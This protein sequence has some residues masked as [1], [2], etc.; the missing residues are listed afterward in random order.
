MMQSLEQPYKGS[1]AQPLSVSEVSQQVKR[2]VE[3]AF[4]YVRV[5]GEIS[6]FKIVGSGH[7][8]FTLKDAGAVLNAVS[9]KGTLPRLGCKPEDGL[10]VIATGKLTIFPGKSQYQLVVERMEAAGVGALMAMLE[11]RKAALLA[12]GLFDSARK[13]P[14]PFLP[15]I[16]GVVT[17]P[18]GAVIRDILHRIEDRMPCRVLVIAVLVQG[19]GAA[20]QIAGAIAAFNALHA[21]SGLRP[22]T[23]IV[24]RGGGS[25]EDLWAFNEEIVVRAAAASAIPLISA[26]GHETD[27]TLIDFASDKRAP[28][29]TAAA[30]M[31]VPVRAELLANLE[32]L[33]ARMRVA[34]QKSLQH[35][36]EKVQAFAR[37]L[38]RP[39]QLL[40]I[41]TQRLDD[42]AERHNRSLVRMLERK[43]EQYRSGAAA[44]SPQIL[45]PLLQRGS[46]Q[47]LLAAER[48]ELRMTTQLR[49][50][51]EQVALLAR[52]LQS[53]DVKAVMQRGFA[54]IRAHDSGAL[55]ASAHAATQAMMQI[56]W[57]DGTLLVMPQE[58]DVAKEQTGKEIKPK[59]ARNSK[60]KP[61]PKPPQGNLF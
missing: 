29:P 61:Q 50:R 45:Q 55:I 21:D 9:W 4:G 3:D 54:L 37:V 1:N 32:M 59:A 28:T 49:T 43:T 46:H 6:Q 17:S 52:M 19:A 38:P 42:W 41:A 2:V 24:A 60:A 33:G 56:E 26:V 27:T 11:K 7:G 14:L 48:L 13:K 53:L 58:S 36:R 31:A 30:E 23:I 25:L 35:S 57:H 12:E 40:A 34:M 18:T 39:E 22:D 47:L 8:Y 44:L 51:A 10:E 5:R 20:E 16:I 15:R